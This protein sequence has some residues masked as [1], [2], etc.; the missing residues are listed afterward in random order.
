M[1]HSSNSSR[2]SRS[3]LR[4]S[5][6][7]L[8]CILPLRFSLQAGAKYACLCPRLGVWEHRQQGAP[9]SCCLQSM[10]PIKAAFFLFSLLFILHLYFIV[11]TEYCV[12]SSLLPVYK[13][14]SICVYNW[15][16]QFRI[17]L[18]VQFAWFVPIFISICFQKKRKE[19]EPNMS[20]SQVT[21]H[22]TEIDITNLPTKSVTFA[23]NTATVTREI[24]G[25]QIKV[26]NSPNLKN[27]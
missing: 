18:S 10:T 24:E 26:S 8:T 17:F 1:S 20:Q 27:E 3:Y 11:D 9:A 4:H 22:S 2:F 12:A 14:L 25:I 13:G 16:S 6:R 5:T 15:L 21:A 23:P 19:K 7:T